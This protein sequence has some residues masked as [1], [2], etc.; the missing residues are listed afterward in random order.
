MNTPNE[1][2]APRP[3]HWLRAIE[4]RKHQLG[5]E[6]RDTLNDKAR[7]GISEEDYA[8]TMA[9]LEKMALNLGWSEDDEFGP[10]GHGFGPGFGRGH[11]RGFGPRFGHGHGHPGHPQR[12]PEN[13]QDASP[14]SEPEA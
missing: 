1:T 11:G 14:V 5:R 9:T 3:S 4:F 7:E 6:Y 8:T 13:A 10:R 12:R 2:T